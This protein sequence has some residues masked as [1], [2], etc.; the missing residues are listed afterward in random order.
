[1]LL[2]WNNLKWVGKT[3]IITSLLLEGANL[4]Q[5]WRMWAEQSALG[6]SLLGW[7]QVNLA[8]ILWWNWYRVV[9]PEQKTAQRMALLGIFINLLVIAS[10]VYFRLQ[11]NK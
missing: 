5:L 2:P 6:Q 11:L 7:I 10:V 4:H 9:T 3:P 8:L 1:M